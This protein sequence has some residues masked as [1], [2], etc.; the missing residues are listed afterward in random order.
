MMALPFFEKPHF[1][2]IH[3]CLAKRTIELASANRAK[4]EKRDSCTQCAGYAQGRTPRGHGS[5]RRVKTRA[6][7]F[8]FDLFGSAG[9]RAGAELLADAFQEML[10]DNRREKIPTRARASLHKVRFEE[11]VFDTLADYQDWRP[12]ARAAVRPVLQRGDFLLWVTGNHLGA[13]PVYDE[14]ARLTPLPLVVQLDAHLDIYN[15]SDCTPELSHGNFL[16]HCDGALPPLINLGHRELLLRADYV[17]RSFRR[18]FAA[19][20]LALDPEP[21]L[22]AVAEAAAQAD[23]VFLDLDCDVFDPAHFPAVAQPQ[24]FGLTPH[25]VLRVLAAIGRDRLAGLILSEFEP[26]RDRH[27]HCLATLL[28][29]IEYV[30]LS[31]YE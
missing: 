1:S 4:A 9:A 15:L 17:A 8:P 7:F 11:F 10:A 22:R 5:E 2:M 12:H 27:D 3:G 13:L 26:A 31:L 25:F 16:L 28:W 19:S 18:T 29:L 20:E 30:L 6:I 14:L 24:P 21:A 23:R